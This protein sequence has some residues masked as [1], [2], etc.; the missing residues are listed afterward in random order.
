MRPQH[1]QNGDYL[2]RSFGLPGLC[3]Y[4]TGKSSRSRLVGPSNDAFS[5]ALLQDRSPIPETSGNV[6]KV[7][8]S[9]ELDALLSSTTNTVVDFYADWCPPCRTIAP[10]FSKLADQYAIKG[11]FAL[12]KVNVDHVHDVA[13]RYG[14]SAM[15]TFVFFEGTKPTPV[16]VSGVSPGPS[17]VASQDG[18]GV[19]RVRGA[20][21]RALTAV[22]KALGE[23]ARLAAGVTSDA[24]GSTKE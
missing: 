13:A 8:K 5:K 20:D 24:D 10:F 9:G 4:R 2:L 19:E 22:V 21:V 17:V 7:L 23:K 18:K 14:I 12:A 1:H 16:A 15:P 11:H 3:A 6:H